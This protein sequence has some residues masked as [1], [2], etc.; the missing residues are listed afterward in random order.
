MP[1]H[2][3]LLHTPARTKSE[4]DFQFIRLPNA[5]HCED[6]QAITT[7]IL[8]AIHKVNGR[9]AP[10][11]RLR[12]CLLNG[13]GV[14]QGKDGV[15]ALEAQVAIHH[16]RAPMLLALQLLEHR[17]GRSISLS[18]ALLV[19]RGLFTFMHCQ[20]KETARTR[21]G[22]A[23]DTHVLLT[24]STR[25]TLRKNMRHHSHLRRAPPGDAC[26]SRWS[27]CMCQT[28]SALVS[29]ACPPPPRLAPLPSPVQQTW[30][31]IR[32]TRKLN[33]ASA[34]HPCGS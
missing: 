24:A 32:S 22:R 9:C 5:G 23:D 15:R 6:M 3:L 25:C 34:N 16:Q 18:P 33:C 20:Q 8:V 27:K 7:R 11:E 14:A 26:V 29:R 13:G 17:S 10:R 30:P 2:P 28:V 1:Q 31:F 21:V 4:A 12:A 19:I